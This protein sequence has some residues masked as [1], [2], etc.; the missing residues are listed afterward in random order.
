[1]RKEDLILEIKGRFIIRNG[2]LTFQIGFD[3]EMDAEKVNALRALA[4]EISEEIQ[5]Q[6][7][8]GVERVNIEISEEY[9]RKISI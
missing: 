6:G 1:M 7:R 4:K 2:R 3:E 8:Y 5:T 9:A